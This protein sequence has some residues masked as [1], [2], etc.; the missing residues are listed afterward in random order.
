[1]AKA[2]RLE[3]TELARAGEWPVLQLRSAAARAGESAVYISAGV[4]GDEPGAVCG[5]L[6]WADA[7]VELLRSGSFVILPCLN[8]QGL[9]LNTRADHRGK[10]LNRLFQNR[11]D[12]LLRSWHQLL[13][14]QDAEGFYVYELDHGRRGVAHA[15]LDRCE[16][17]QMGRDPR[18]SIDGMRARRGVIR[19]KRVPASL[20][21]LPEAIVLF[22]SG[23][24][25]SLTFET[26]SEF[27]LDARAEAHAR[28]IE[29]TIEVTQ[30]VR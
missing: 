21:G 28:F 3:I 23:C 12:P 24:P 9:V 18:S 17:G 13:N 5:L 22:Q 4:H 2:A 15:I 10:D 16:H 26:P 6:A 20:P 29:A 1:L 27:S 14:E 19:R 8:P 30:G 11:R 25:L 7:N